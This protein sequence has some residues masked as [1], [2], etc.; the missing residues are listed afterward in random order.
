[1]EKMMIFEEKGKYSL[2]RDYGCT[3]DALINGAERLGATVVYECVFPEDL[4]KIG[5]IFEY[6]QKCNS[7]EEKFDKKRLDNLL[8]Q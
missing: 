7:K 5:N 4:E 8:I 3:R 1:M 6:I 2:K